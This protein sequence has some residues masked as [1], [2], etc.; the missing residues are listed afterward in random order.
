MSRIQKTHQLLSVLLLVALI[1]PMLVIGSYAS[2]KFAYYFDFTTNYTRQGQKNDVGTSSGGTAGVSITAA[3]FAL[4][5]VRFYLLDAEGNRACNTSA[6]YTTLQN[7]IGLTY[8]SGAAL[9]NNC[10]VTLVGLREGNTVYVSG[11]FQP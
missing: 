4:G 11:N 9:Y 6:R 5:N 3:D 2:D 1:I 8:N 10:Y 7:S